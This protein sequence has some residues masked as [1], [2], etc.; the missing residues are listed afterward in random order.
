VGASLFQIVPFCHI[1]TRSPDIEISI[2]YSTKP[3]RR[4]LIILRSRYTRTN[5]KTMPTQRNDEE[6]KGDDD[7]DMIYLS[8]AEP[9]IGSSFLP[10]DVDEEEEVPG[11]PDQT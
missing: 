7:E 10:I 8:E 2:L 6:A 4:D 5:K 1:L 9:L 11:T 3:R